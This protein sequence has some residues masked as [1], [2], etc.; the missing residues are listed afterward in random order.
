MAVNVFGLH[1]SKLDASNLLLLCNRVRLHNKNMRGFTSL[2]AFHIFEKS[3]KVEQKAYELEEKT[4][5][6]HDNLHQEACF[7]RC[8]ADQIEEEYKYNNIVKKVK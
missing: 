3:E 6:P 1:L 8:D 7:M 4:G 2:H 5:K